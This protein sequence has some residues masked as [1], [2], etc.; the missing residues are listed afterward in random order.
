MA[1]AAGIEMQELRKGGDPD[2][3]SS[4][5]TV[6]E[7]EG[8]VSSAVHMNDEE[9]ATP[10]DPCR[11]FCCFGFR[12][13]GQSYVVR[14]RA[15]FILVGPH[16]IGVLVTLSLIVVSTVLFIGQ[17][18][19]GLDAWYTCLSVFMCIATT[20]FLFKTTCT[21]PGIVPR[22]TLHTDPALISRC[23]YCGVDLRPLSTTRMIQLRTIDICDVHQSRHTEHCD[24]CGV[25]I[26]K[27]DH[28]CPWMGKCIGKANMKWFQL[29]N[30]AWVLYLVFVL[31]VTMQNASAHADLLV[32]AGNH[33][34]NHVQGSSR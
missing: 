7:E 12:K 9:Y 28:H 20:Y 6:D 27:Y 1:S 21:D 22:G 5:T 26:E 34:I 17:Q 18:C 24:D 8:L 2:R 33:F 23:S 32:K 30:L 14:E 4:T 10:T 31:V 16:W 11:C 19:R 29:F 15:P 25:C 3:T 13:I